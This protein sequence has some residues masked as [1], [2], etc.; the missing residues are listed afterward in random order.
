MCGRPR[1]PSKPAARGAAA[2][3]GAS[4]CA[5]PACAGA[6]RYPVL[7]LG[8]KYPSW[9][10][11]ARNR[12]RRVALSGLRCCCGGWLR[13]C[14]RCRFRRRFGPRRLVIQAVAYPRAYAPQRRRSCV[15]PASSGPAGATGAAARRRGS[16]P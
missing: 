2:G 11:F 4:C 16:G 5:S 14:R 8:A 12:Q 13:L 3:I 6:A 1:V 15:R 9:P 7:P 10:F